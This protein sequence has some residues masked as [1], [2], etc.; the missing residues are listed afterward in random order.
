[1]FLSLHFLGVH[2]KSLTKTPIEEHSRE[3][4]ASNS[5][6]H[7]GTHSVSK[8]SVAGQSPIVP[9]EGET[10]AT[11]GVSFESKHTWGAAGAGAGAGAAAAGVDGD[12]HVPLSLSF[13]AVPHFLSKS[14]S[15]PSICATK[16]SLQMGVQKLLKLSMDSQSPG[17]ML[18][19]AK[20]MSASTHAS[21]GTTATHSPA[22]FNLSPALHDLSN[23]LPRKPSLQSGVQKFLYLSVVLQSPGRT[24]SSAKPL[25]APKQ[26]GVDAALF[27]ADG[28]VVVVVV[29]EEEEVVE[30][31]V[32]VVGEG[33]GEM[34]SVF[35]H[36]KLF[37]NSF[38]VSVGQKTVPLVVYPGLHVGTQD[39]PRSNSFSVQ[40]PC[41]AWSGVRLAPTQGLDGE[42]LAPPVLLDCDFA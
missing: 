6:K 17:R 36:V 2:A 24:F 37:I 8:F 12:T 4:E 3:P 28:A 39:F 27:G 10:L 29:E 22:S 31:E 33:E 5:G 7:V 42:P 20:P 32:A 34:G 16:P 26:S 40:V 11:K 15:L 38:L 35:V 25:S 1:M 14:S 18:S 41:D 21:T 30:E 9:C 19:A 13:F 23:S